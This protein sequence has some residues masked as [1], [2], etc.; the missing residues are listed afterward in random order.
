MEKNEI[1]ID[2]EKY[3][4]VKIE[5]NKKE[6]D[7]DK[8]G[9][10]AVDCHNSTRCDNSTDCHN[11][12]YCDNSAYC[13][14]SVYCHNSTGCHNSTRC[15]NSAYCDNSAYCYNSAFLFFCH[16]LVLEKYRIFNKQVSKDRYREVKVKISLYLPFNFHPEKITEEQKQWL[17][18]NIAE[19]DEEV[20]QKII[21]DGILPVRPRE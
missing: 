2:G 5:D 11:S 18:Q 6:T 14:N 4:L 20:M 19:Y 12:A 8:N 3:K 17:K 10:N 13:Y 21:D 7:K 1:E 15:Y 9:V 16:D